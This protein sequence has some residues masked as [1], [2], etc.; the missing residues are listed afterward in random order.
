MDDDRF[1]THRGIDR[2]ELDE[3]DEA[4]RKRVAEICAFEQ[5]QMSGMNGEPHKRVRMAAQKGFGSPRALDMADYVKRL[6]GEIADRMAE[7]G[8]E[9]AIIE[10]AYR[11]P[12]LV[13][14][15]M[16]GAPVED[17]DL[18]RRWSYALPGV[19][20]FAGAAIPQEKRTSVV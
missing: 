14:M 20:E 17:M 19:Q 10:L 8:G 16:L 15:R 18:L 5:L 2:F 3:L 11:V 9:A 13:V 4:D 7:A 1:L 12:L 6:V